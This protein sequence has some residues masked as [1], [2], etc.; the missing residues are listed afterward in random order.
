MKPVSSHALPPVL[1]PEAPAVSD[2]TQP[3][4]EAAAAAAPAP[5]SHVLNVSSQ[6]GRG[7]N[8]LAFQH[9]GP[10]FPTPSDDLGRFITQLRAGSD[11]D[12]RDMLQLVQRHGQRSVSQLPPAQRALLE[13]IPAGLRNRLPEL[14]QRLQTEAGL[15]DVQNNALRNPL[16]MQEL[17]SEI[18]ALASAIE[19]QNPSTLQ[20][21]LVEASA[22]LSPEARTYFH[23]L[24]LHQPENKALLLSLAERSAPIQA[25]LQTHMT[26]ANPADRA[27]YFGRM[28]NLSA[29]LLGQA[30]DLH[31]VDMAQHREG[32]GQLMLLAQELD[33]GSRQLMQQ[34]LQHQGNLSSF[35]AESIDINAGLSAVVLRSFQQASSQP[36]SERQATR[37]LLARLQ[38]T[39]NTELSSADQQRLRALGL[40]HDAA[41]Q[42]VNLVNR[43]P[44]DARALQTLSTMHQQLDRAQNGGIQE[45]MLGASVQLSGSM[46]EMLEASGIANRLEAAIEAGNAVLQ[47][48]EVKAQEL[49]E[50][51]GLKTEEVRAG[52]INYEQILSENTVLTEI[53]GPYMSESGGLDVDALLGGIDLGRLNGVLEPLGITVTR[54]PGQ[55]P[56]IRDRNGQPITVPALRERLGAHIQER[57]ALQRQA[58]DNLRRGEAELSA[59]TAESQALEGRIAVETQAQEGRL[60]EYRGV[61]TR[62][63]NLPLD[64]LAE[65]LQNPQLRASL[66]PED[67]ALLEQRLA[68]AGRHLSEGPAL[69]AASEAQIDR[70]RQA[71]AELQEARTAAEAELVLTRASLARGDALLKDLQQLKNAALDQQQSEQLQQLLQE[72]NRL[73]FLLNLNPRPASVDVNSL[74]SDWQKL[75]REVGQEFNQQFIDQLNQQTLEQR[76]LDQEAEKSREKQE[77]H[78][79]KLGDLDAL[80]RKS[81]V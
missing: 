13:Q 81:V 75:L 1:R 25:A 61:L 76:R 32:A 67:L 16:V 79:Q 3:A 24:G 62:L 50:A 42:L 36:A 68:D 37:E 17:L 6:A 58:H 65:Q 29:A 20:Q 66:R 23:A 78:Q 28:A 73:G 45:G 52:R 54:E 22:R 71:G 8:H 49:T 51:I 39:G 14:A 48:L 9:E 69:I 47:G 77:Y 15:R 38:S 31:A 4:Q 18:S 55:P 57:I 64:Q 59:M 74:I 11:K 21:T 5:V 80:D 60:A 43:Q 46:R 35:P 72:A 40:G 44:V 26:D 63:Q 41:G 7:L 10:Q 33:P 30:E 12:L 2:K 34:L 19:G 56:S 70:T 27:D 53:I